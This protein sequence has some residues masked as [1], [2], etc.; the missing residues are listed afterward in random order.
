MERPEALAARW[1]QLLDD[2]RFDDA[3]SLLHE[4]C[5]YASPGG[6]I[7]GPSSILESYRRNAAWAH[8]T[9][10]H[11]EWESDLA[12]EG[13]G[14][15]RI[16]FTDRTVHRGVSHVYR[17]QQLVRVEAGRVRHIE[18]VSIPHE[19]ERLAAFFKRVGVERS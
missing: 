10:E 5:E 6:T 14:R 16:T 17:C 7:R 4:D 12:L 8:E 18:H 3:R 1:A 2:E 15:V 19:E 13:D 9:F 11:I